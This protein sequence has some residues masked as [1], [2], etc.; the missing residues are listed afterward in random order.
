M[1]YLFSLKEGMI[2][3]IEPGVFFPTPLLLI[4][5]KNILGIYVPPTAK[6][7][8][9]FHNIGI[10]IEVSCIILYLLLDLLLHSNWTNWTQDVVLVGSEYPI[11]LSASAPKEV[12]IV[13]YQFSKSVWP[14]S[15]K[16]RRRW[17]NVPG[18]LG[19]R[20]IWINGRRQILAYLCR[21]RY[22][23]NIHD[24]LGLIVWHI[25]CDAW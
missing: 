25:S 11:V 1:D 3:T 17:R 22:I 20:S 6:F 13:E 18:T 14:S 24:T 8:K 10:R 2:I 21:I 7:P 15:G 19:I 23:Y 5:T 12:N 16:G 9:H 4:F